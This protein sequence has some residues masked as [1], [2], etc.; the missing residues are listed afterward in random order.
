MQFVSEAKRSE[1]FDGKVHELVEFATEWADRMEDVIASGKQ[2]DEIEVAG[3]IDNCLSRCAD[4]P[5]RIGQAK[6]MLV[7][8]WVHGE[9]LAT[10][11]IDF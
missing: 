6:K 5:K 1:F 3:A 7:G 4:I 8:A 11:D 9:A 10:M 2:L